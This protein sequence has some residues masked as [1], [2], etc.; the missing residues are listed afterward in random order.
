MVIVLFLLT[1]AVLI[2]VNYFLRKEDRVLEKTEK[3]KKS[4]IF[5]SPDKALIPL[6]DSA[7]RLYHLSHS[8]VQES[9]EDYVYVGYDNFIPYL[10][11]EHLPSSGGIDTCTVSSYLENLDQAQYR[12]KKNTVIDSVK[13]GK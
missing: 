9:D 3:S 7:K 11:V 1:A 5:L 8:W 6:I 12:G 10:P 4:P 2:T 13:S